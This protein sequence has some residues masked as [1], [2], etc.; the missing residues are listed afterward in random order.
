[1]KVTKHRHFDYLTP[2]RE[3]QNEDE[4]ETIF[5]LKWPKAVTMLSTKANFFAEM[6]EETRRYEAWRAAGFSSFESFCHDELEMTLDEVETLVRGVRLAGGKTVTDKEAKELGK[7]G[8]PKKG[9]EKG[10]NITF[11]EVERGTNKSYTLARLRR[12]N[13]ELFDRVEA[14]E[15]SANAAAIE[16]G[17]RKKPTPL[18]SAKRAIGI[19]QKKKQRFGFLGTAQL[20]PA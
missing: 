11:S 8:R 15:L 16:A 7:Q 1:M 9:E 18:E 3:A 10:N 19:Y 20:H 14:G 17:W 13:P 12:D 6:V 4:L 5:R 2:M